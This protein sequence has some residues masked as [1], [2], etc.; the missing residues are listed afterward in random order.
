VIGVLARLTFRGD[1]EPVRK[2]PGDRPQF[3]L[4]RLGRLDNSGTSAVSFAV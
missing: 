4:N 3:E 2:F 1:P